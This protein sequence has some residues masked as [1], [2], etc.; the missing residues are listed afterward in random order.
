MI[1]ARG[2]CTVFLRGRYDI[3]LYALK[4]VEK[5]GVLYKGPPGG[6][7]LQTAEVGVRPGAVTVF[8]GVEK[9]RNGAR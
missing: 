6:E 2:E 5:D 3:T 8:D 4:F 1:P 7:E 9:N